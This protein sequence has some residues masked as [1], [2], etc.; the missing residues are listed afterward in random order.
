[1]SKI[2]DIILQTACGLQE[3]ARQFWSF[4]VE[5]NYLRTGQRINKLRQGMYAV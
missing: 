2:G 1:M 3:R 4:F 5:L